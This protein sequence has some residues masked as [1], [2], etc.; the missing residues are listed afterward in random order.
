MA[1]A[2]ND[3]FRECTTL[4]GCCSRALWSCGKTPQQGRWRPS[5]YSWGTRHVPGSTGVLGSWAARRGPMHH[6]SPHRSGT[7]GTWGRCKPMGNP[8]NTLPLVLRNPACR[9]IWSS[10]TFRIPWKSLRLKLKKLNCV[11]ISFYYRNH[12]AFN[13]CLRPHFLWVDIYKWVCWQF[14]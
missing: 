13:L 6:P 14:S 12:L 9:R 3:S 1:L 7:H 5:L 4:H 2:L 11:F 8:Q 10:R